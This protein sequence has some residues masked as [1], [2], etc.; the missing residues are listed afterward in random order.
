MEP[1]ES[2]SHLSFSFCRRGQGRG[3]AAWRRAYFGMLE[4]EQPIQL[5]DKTGT[6]REHD[7]I[8]NET[9]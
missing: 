6:Q 3:T 2:V 4:E 8:L 5:P 7:E 1:H 9:K